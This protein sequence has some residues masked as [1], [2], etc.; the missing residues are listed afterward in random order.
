MFW[1]ARVFWSVYGRYAEFE[2]RPGIEK[3][4][5]LCCCELDGGVGASKVDDVCL[6]KILLLKI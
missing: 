3:G 2:G 1:R 6:R 5:V 4:C